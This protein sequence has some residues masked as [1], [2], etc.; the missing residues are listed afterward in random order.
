MTRHWHFIEQFFCFALFFGGF[1]WCGEGGSVQRS[2]QTF[3]CRSLVQAARRSPQFLESG[4]PWP[5][6][7]DRG[8][9]SPL[10]ALCGYS[11]I[12]LQPYDDRAIVTLLMDSSLHGFH[13]CPQQTCTFALCSMEVQLSPLS[14]SSLCHNTL[15]RSLSPLEVSQAFVS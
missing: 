5:D 8:Y 1:W 10:D 11:I 7:S 6:C 3:G 12:R 4:G 13:I 9:L 2:A 15:S 14:L